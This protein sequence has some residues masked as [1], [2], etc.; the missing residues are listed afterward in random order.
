MART[1]DTSV[2]LQGR[3][4]GAPPRQTEQGVGRVSGVASMALLHEAIRVNRARTFTLWRLALQAAV[5]IALVL[6][7]KPAHADGFIGNPTE[8]DGE[9]FPVSF[10]T[11]GPSRWRPSLFAP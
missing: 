7:A 6:T 8:D 11:R 10:A 2:T 9:M 1:Y 3:L 4:P 5:L